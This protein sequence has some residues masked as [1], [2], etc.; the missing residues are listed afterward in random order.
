MIT[1][2][3]GSYQRDVVYLLTTDA[4]HWVFLINIFDRMSSKKK[5]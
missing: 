4:T 3:I 5:K 1:T 2:E